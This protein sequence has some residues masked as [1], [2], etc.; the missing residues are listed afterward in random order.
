MRADRRYGRL[1]RDDP[2]VG[3]GPVDVAAVDRA[4]GLASVEP[5]GPRAHLVDLAG[6]AL[7]VDARQGKGLLA[8]DLD[9]GE[10]KHAGARFLVG[11]EIG[12]IEQ[13]AVATDAALD[14]EVPRGVLGLAHAAAS[15][16][17]AGFGPST[18]WCGFLK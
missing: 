13:R 12:V 10:C 3:L 18:C 14:A 15:R 16:A 11:I 2:A 6:S 5:A 8:A 17:A 7:E 4:Q 1:G 9:H